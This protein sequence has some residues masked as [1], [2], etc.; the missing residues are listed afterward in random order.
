MTVTAAGSGAD[1]VRDLASA[2]AAELEPLLVLEPLERFLDGAGLGSGPLEAEPIG[3]GH[4]NVTFLLRRGDRRLVLRRPPRGPLPPSAHDVLREARLLGALDGLGPPVPEVLASC[5]DDAVIG[6][7]FYVMP[8]IA[9]HV[10]A[11]SL[12]AAL[13]A[14]GTAERIA[15]Q[16]V[17]GLVALHGLDFEALGLAGFGR[18]EGYLERQIKRF[19]GLLEHNATR[20]LPDLERVGGW[21]ADQVPDSPAATIVHGDYRLGNVMFAPRRPRLVAVLDWEMATIGDPLADLGYMTAMWAQDGEPANPV[22]ELSRVTRLPGFPPR[23]A[24][25]ERYVEATGHPL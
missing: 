2:V 20:Q 17:D 22:A 10:L 21:L 24:L 23:E 19:R 25:A 18:A 12:P 4:S 3:E 6:A 9:G 13:S 14:D 11:E 15:E 16:L 8:F 5:E 1:V 7:P